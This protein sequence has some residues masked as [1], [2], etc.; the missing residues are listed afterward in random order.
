MKSTVAIDIAAPADL[1]FRLARDVERWARLLPHYRS[2]HVVGRDR[3]VLT[4]RFVALRPL[5]PALGLG[6]PVVWLSDAWHEPE[7][8]RLRF[9]HRRGATRGMDVTWFIEPRGDGCRVT[10]QHAFGARIPGWAW[11]IDRGFVRPIA[12]RT[13]ASFKA[14]A[15][16]ATE[17]A[18][19]NDS[20]AS[21]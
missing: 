13:L 9:V 10:I 16:A 21:T 18:A 5:V 2:V 20:K 11:L 8:R 12:T 1:V 4:A 14:I 17:A 7:A 15:E 6:V 3:G 19:P